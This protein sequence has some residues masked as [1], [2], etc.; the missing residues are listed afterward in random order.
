MLESET[1]LVSIEGRVRNHLGK[2][3]HNLRLQIPLIES[4]FPEIKG[5]Y[6]GSINLELEVPL[7][8]VAP[9]HRTKPIPWRDNPQET[10]VFDFLR[11]KIE[12]PIDSAPEPA[13]L[14]IPHDSPHRR[15]PCLHEVIANCR[16]PIDEGTRCRI[17]I[18][19]TAIRI[20]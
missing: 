14:Y 15:T 7:L 1:I 6:L 19:P 4:E 13:W 9:D 3:T 17:W 12:A 11:I 18:D 20:S 5:C 10:G 16:L 8:V 2:A